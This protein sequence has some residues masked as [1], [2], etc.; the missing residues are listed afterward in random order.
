MVDKL[1]DNLMNYLIIFFDLRVYFINN[2][3]IKMVRE[4]YELV[5]F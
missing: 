3:L 2:E 5:C 1:I 4:I